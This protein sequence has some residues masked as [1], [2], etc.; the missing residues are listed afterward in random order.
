MVRIK[1]SKGDSAPTRIRKF[2]SKRMPGL[3]KLKYKNMRQNAFVFY[4]G[5]CHLF[6]ED[7][8]SDSSLNKSPHTWVCGDLH[9]ENIGSY[10]ADNR[11]VYFDINDFDE[12]A[13]APCLWDVA[14]LQTSIMIANNTLGADKTTVLNLSKNFLDCYVNTLKDGSARLVEKG[15]ATGM[16]RSFLENRENRKR[17]KFVDSRTVKNGNSRKLIVDNLHVAPLEK[18][19]KE[20]IIQAINK[21]AAQQSRPGFYK[22]LD[23]GYRIAGTGSLGLERYVL[24]VEGNGK[25]EGHYLLDL[26]ISNPSCL[27][28][29]LIAPQPK[30]ENQAERIIHIQKRVQA[31]PLA[32]LSSI[33]INND[34]FVLKELQPTLD[35][36]D[37]RLCKGKLS[38]LN[39]VIKTMAEITAWDQLRSGG[40]QGS[41]ITD[42][43]L[44]FANATS[45]KKEL[46]SYCLHYTEQVKNDYKQYA[47][48]FDDGYFA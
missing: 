42:E 31:F 48:A 9:L 13:L 39:P 36:F 19:R 43:L 30:W 6:Y 33:K 15:T 4:R 28:H 2:N 35:K 14:R 32:L 40:R 37:L 20:E 5:S 21:W 47:Q 41:A 24:L 26:K 18:K 23:V 3:L 45:W 44:Y 11:L 8:P 25:R 27:D 12:S 17:K 34:W 38:K 16:V 7:L 1:N 10:K 46:N 29:Y 22:V